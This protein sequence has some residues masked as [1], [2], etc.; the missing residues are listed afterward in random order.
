VSAD[1]KFLYVANGRGA[2]G[3]NPGETVFNRQDNQYVYQLQKS[4]LLSFPTPSGSTLESLTDQVQKN[5][6]FDSKLSGK[7]AALIHELQQRIKHVIY[8]VKENRT[9][10]QVLGDLPIGN[11]DP[12]LVDYGRTI[13]PDFHAIAEQFVDL[14]NFYCSSD[15]SGDGHAWAFAGREND[16]TQKIIPLN[17]SGRGTSYDTEGQNR[18]INVG[19]ATVKARL[20]WNPINPTDP[21]IL[22]G[23]ADVGAMDGPGEGDIQKGYIWNAVEGAG[24]TFRNY[25]Y[26]CDQAEYSL[27]VNPTPL[28]RNPFSKKLRVGFASGPELIGT[29]DPYFRSFD[30][31]FPDFW[32]EKEWEREFDGY[33]KHGN[34]PALSM[35]RLM[36]DHTGSFS[37][38]IDGVNTVEIQQADN[39][40]AV[41]K[42]IDKVA[43]SPYKFDTLIFI[44]EDDSQDGADHVDSHRSTA[45]IVGP[46][47]K[48]GVVV[49]TKYT[50][51]NMLRTIEDV[52]GVD[53]IDVLTA[54]ERPMTD[55][56][57]IKQ[58]HWTFNA[59]PSIYLYN[60]Q[61]PLPPRFA[62][63][64]HIPKPT[65]TASYWAEKTKGFDFTHEDALYDPGK[66]K[67]I[68]WEGL[69]G[70]K[71]YPTV[72]SG[73]DL[74]QN[75]QELLKKA[76]IT[77]GREGVASTES[78]ASVQ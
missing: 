24:L 27:R 40:Y 30:T 16:L 22:P 42:L 48:H 37:S 50:H 69:H 55:V 64:R 77:L 67:R 49:S 31:A 35:V 73:L 66:F 25:G 41:A 74:R 13:T 70:H 72:R 23:V 28:E 68:I 54:S 19:L 34:L 59:V 33:V 63:G 60:T 5:D 44:N 7:D 14:D 17:Y 51:I 57:D 6:H 46:D 39:D 3:P 36:E 43:H 20:A 75:R 61:L 71:T 45:Y 53:H 62:K 12:S 65:H 47:V 11:G 52:L 1:G 29:T 15:V 8:I 38:A 26:Y 56:F 21:D 2:T 4:Y 18:D 58:K 9:Y 32:R 78:S 76:A 10:D